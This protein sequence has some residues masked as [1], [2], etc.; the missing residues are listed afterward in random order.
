[1][2][3]IPRLSSLKRSEF[4]HRVLRSSHGLC[5]IKCLSCSPPDG[6]HAPRKRWELVSSSHSHSPISVLFWPRMIQI[7]E[8]LAEV[9]RSPR[10]LWDIPTL[11]LQQFR[12]HSKDFTNASSYTGRSL[13]LWYISKMWDLELA[14]TLSASGWV[15]SL[16]KQHSNVERTE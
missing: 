4:T 6:I 9:W 16:Q 7:S 14:W 12:C 8:W 3:V 1:M 5:V 10:V 11:E 13:D 15:S 2:K